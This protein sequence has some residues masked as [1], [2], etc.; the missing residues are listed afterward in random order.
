MR[1]INLEEAIFYSKE[2]IRHG[3]YYSGKRFR[4]Y[5]KGFIGASENISF[6][7]EHEKFDSDKALTILGGGDHVF[8]LIFRDVKEIDAIDVNK[9]EYFVFG[10]RKAMIENL[11]Y[12]EFMHSNIRFDN[13]C[14]DFLEQ[15]LEKS[16]RSLTEDVYEY[17]RKIFEF[18][19]KSGRLENLYYMVIGDLWK[20]YNIYLANEETYLDLRDKLKKVKINL[21]FEDARDLVKH[22]DKTYDL[23]LLSNI[24][25]YL[26]NDNHCLTLEEFNS[27]IR[28]FYNLLNDKGLIINYLYGF[29]DEFLFKNSIITRKDIPNS[30]LV[31]LGETNQGFYRIRKLS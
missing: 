15:M 27:F 28:T 2:I 13:W 7:L 26:G 23:I 5:S 19:K 25:D 29:K 12:T 21:Y 14:L 8:N 18:C 1:D 22:L 16:K 20:S 6:C 3:D 24:A 11:T 17:Y 30:N 10:L 9:L 31:R 4:T